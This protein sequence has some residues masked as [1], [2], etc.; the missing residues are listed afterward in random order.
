[1]AKQHGTETVFVIAPSLINVW[2]GQ[3]EVEDFLEKMSHTYGTQF[4]NFSDAIQDP[5]LFYD[6]HHLN[7]RGVE[8]FAKD[9]L[10]GIL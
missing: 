8:I 3:S 2:P 5:H 9:Y 4:Y 7:S 1:M 6:H 10:C